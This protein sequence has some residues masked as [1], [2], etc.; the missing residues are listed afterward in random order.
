[1]ELVYA[2]EK[3]FNSRV[4]KLLTFFV[5][6]GSLVSPQI[7][8][9]GATGTIT[10]TSNYLTS[11]VY[12]PGIQ[13]TGNDAWKWQSSL[14][15]QGLSKDMNT[16]FI[17]FFNNLYEP[18]TQWRESTKT[19]TWDW[20][21]LDKQVKAIFATGAEP[22]IVLGFYSWTSKS[23]QVPSGM[24]V[25]S[26]TGGLPSSSSWA[27]YCE[28]YVSHFKK[29]NLPVRYYEIFNEP[30]NYWKVDGWPAPQPKL[31][32]FTKLFNAA[33][34]AM[35]SINSSVR[36]GNDS[37]NMQDVL[38]YFIE[39]KVK[40]DFLS[41]HNYATGST[42]SLD[43]DLFNAA[44]TKYLTDTE[45]YYST[46][47]ARALYKAAT[48]VYLPVLITEGNLNYAYSSGTDPRIQKMAGAVYQALRIKTAIINNFVTDIYFGFASSA[49]QEKKL[50]THGY[51]FGM[52]NTDT[53]KPWYPYYVVQLI[54]SNISVGDKIYEVESTLS[55]ITGL[56]W[57]HGNVKNVLIISKISSANTI[58]IKG[59]SSQMTYQ[60]VDNTISYNT[61]S[62]QKGTI[63]PYSSITLNGYTVMLLKTVI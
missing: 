42:S 56:S 16:K 38:D 47:K 54:G 51:G 29:L 37:S 32:Y 24:T 50:A 53:S 43:S 14:T 57:I 59:I 19:G 5:V 11:D 36:I 30:C 6:I 21:E 22:I 7:N 62:I 33:A 45:S 4:T 31:G 27:A 26:T 34:I 61:P 2:M 48:G 12:S 13:L 41:Y 25:Y 35:R 10:V 60:K 58:T 63:N 23:L 46:S 52:V 55:G 8:V 18:C 9:F 15:L 17:R 28:E 49:Y 40:I 44:E 39:N 20:T 1:L 3:I